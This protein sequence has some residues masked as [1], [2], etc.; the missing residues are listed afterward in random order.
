MFVVITADNVIFIRTFNP[1]CFVQTNKFILIQLCAVR[2]IGIYSNT[3]CLG[4]N[5]ITSHS[6]IWR[7]LYLFLNFFCSQYF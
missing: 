6:H 4:G 5:Y 1:Q 3:I 7:F 2:Y